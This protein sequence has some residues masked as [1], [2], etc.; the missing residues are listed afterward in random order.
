MLLLRPAVDRLALD[1]EAVRD[2][3]AGSILPRR[4]LITLEGRAARRV[5]GLPS[6][7]SFAPS[8]ALAA[9]LPL[10]DV[11]DRAVVRRGSLP[12]EGVAG[13][14]IGLARG[15]L[16]ACAGVVDGARA[17]GGGERGDERLK[18]LRAGTLDML[19]VLLRDGDS[20]PLRYGEGVVKVSGLKLCP[21]TVSRMLT[22]EFQRGLTAGR[23]VF[24]VADRVGVPSIVRDGVVARRSQGSVEMC[25]PF[26]VP[27]GRLE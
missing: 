16:V 20:V 25:G 22:L 23:S 11:A 17:E 13:D 1:V 27:M 3:G 21:T 14:C 6:F 15:R 19:D 26:G 4:L 9:C 18:G 24:G 12:L 10:A 5:V 7:P 8:S 2:F